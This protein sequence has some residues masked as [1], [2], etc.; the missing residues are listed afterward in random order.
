MTQEV[1]KP[2][3][4][5]GWLAVDALD[6]DAQGVARRPDGKVVFIDGAL[7]GEAVSVK[8]QRRGLQAGQSGVGHSGL[9]GK[10][11]KRHDMIAPRLPPCPLY[12]RD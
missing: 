11:R 1:T 3:L 2:A 9:P 4:P 7:P 6:I 12:L 8:V 10:S 5:D